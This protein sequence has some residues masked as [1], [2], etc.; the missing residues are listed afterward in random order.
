MFYKQNFFTFEN[1]KNKRIN[2]MTVELING[3]VFEIDV[4]DIVDSELNSELDGIV[5]QL[6]TGIKITIKATEE[7][8]KIYL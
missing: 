4:D 8:K 5:L 7:N 1:F 3:G 2:K 6:N